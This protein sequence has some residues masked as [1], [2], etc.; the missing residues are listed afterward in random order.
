MSTS[1]SLQQRLLQLKKLQADLPSVMRSAARDATMRAI[2]ATMDA[3]PPKENTGRLAGVNMLTG[4]LK[5]HWATDSKTSPQETGGRFV[6]YL[7]NDLEYASY[8]NDGHRMDRHFVPGLYVGDDGKLNY[9]PTAKVGLVVG[10]KTAYVKGKFMVDK[11]KEAY[12]EALKNILD[13]E[14]ERRLK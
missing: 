4:E 2:E 1:V 13:A 7:A 11:G 5:A 10:T 3:T 8:V 14:I 9:D 6:T 12:Q